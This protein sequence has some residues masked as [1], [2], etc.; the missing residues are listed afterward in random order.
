MVNPGEASLN[1]VIKDKPKVLPQNGASRARFPSGCGIR[2]GPKGKWSGP[3]VPNSSD[4]DGE[5]P[6]KRRGLNHPRVPPAERGKPVA[7]PHG[8]ASRK[9]SRHGC[10]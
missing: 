1:V 8:K 7:L 5:P 6:A 4:A 9:V 10:G 2:L 3:G